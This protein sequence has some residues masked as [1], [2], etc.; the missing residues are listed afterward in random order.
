MRSGMGEFRN[1]SKFTGKMNVVCVLCSFC[2][3][4]GCCIVVVV[5][6]LP[7]A[8]LGPSVT[9]FLVTVV[10]MQSF[11]VT[12]GRSSSFCLSHSAALSLPPDEQFTFRQGDKKNSIQNLCDDIVENIVTTL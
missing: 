9:L 2:C 10:I 3:F 5:S 6:V 8:V 12:S 7:R 11:H 4:T 1:V